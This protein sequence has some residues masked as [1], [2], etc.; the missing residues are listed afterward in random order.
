MQS[1]AGS[2]SSLFMSQLTGSIRQVGIAA[3]FARHLAAIQGVSTLALHITKAATT[4]RA[5]QLPI[6]ICSTAREAVLWAGAVALTKV[7]LADAI[8]TGCLLIFKHVATVTS[9]PETLQLLP[10]CRCVV[11]CNK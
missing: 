8:A 11:W 5:P 2:L 7:W 10:G 6:R 3:G 9:T 1:A 4:H